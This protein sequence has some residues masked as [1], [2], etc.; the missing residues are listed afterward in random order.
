MNSHADREIVGTAHPSDTEAAPKYLSLWAGKLKSGTGSQ[1]IILAAGIPTSSSAPTQAAPPPPVR[2]PQVQASPLSDEAAS[3]RTSDRG[4]NFPAHLSFE[5]SAVFPCDFTVLGS[6]KGR[7]EL[8]GNSKMHIATGGCF[9]G[10]LVA[11]N[12][13]VDG[14]AHGAI[15]ASGGFVGFGETARCTGSIKYGRM[16]MADGAEVEA[17]M[18]RAA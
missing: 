15:D 2:N 9:E 8:T 7:V 4:C 6:I 14:Q 16:S 12:I 5:G 17:T 10:D 3:Q 11:K 18:K 1:S 13:S